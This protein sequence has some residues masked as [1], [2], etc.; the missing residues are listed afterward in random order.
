MYRNPNLRWIWAQPKFFHTCGSIIAHA[1]DSTTRAHT[2]NV[3]APEPL[4]P[5][6]SLPG[7]HLMNTI[8][9]TSVVK[10]TVGGTTRSIVGS[11]SRSDLHHRVSQL[12]HINIE[13]QARPLFF[14]AQRSHNNQSQSDNTSR[15]GRIWAGNIAASVS[16][17]HLP[18]LPHSLLKL[19]SCFPS[20]KQMKGCSQLQRPAELLPT[21]EAFRLRHTLLARCHGSSGRARESGTAAEW[22]W[23]S[24]AG[25][26][27]KK[28][29]MRNANHIGV[30][31]TRRKER[32]VRRKWKPETPNPLKD[33]EVN[34]K[35][36]LTEGC[37]KRKNI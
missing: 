8:N 18:I 4:R 6:W 23:E 31:V 32:Q 28:R 5:R 30:A 11:I 12:Q 14:S 21:E 26:K 29:L 7:V 17:V 1:A 27:K 16:A 10:Y 36:K 33:K 13:P 37:R 15:S 9:H 35:E 19:A 34:G 3:R 2:R 24:G 25:K 22:Q 20:W